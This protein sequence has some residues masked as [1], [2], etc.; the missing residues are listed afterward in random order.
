MTD[1]DKSP[2]AYVPWGTFKNAVESLVSG[3]PN[4]VDRSVF[5]G[6][7]GGVQYQLLAAL[8]FLGFADADERPTETLRRLA[9]ADEEV[10]KERLREAFRSKYAPVF[11][12]ELTNATPAELEEVF[13]EAYGISGTTRVKAIRFF[14]AG[15]DYLGIPVSTLL[16]KARKANGASLRRSRA[17]KKTTKTRSEPLPSMPPAAASG[18]S[19][20]VNLKSG[21]T[22]TVSATLDLFSLS[23]TDRSFVFQLI[24]KLEDYENA[25]KPEQDGQREGT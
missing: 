6:L 7:S 1:S 20:V 8:K 18:T 24:D 11:E 2:V 22:L 21:G 14:L 4:R 12:L 23:P 3:I 5:S 17:N 13:T 9:V 15:A 25:S 19:K 16:S 10:R